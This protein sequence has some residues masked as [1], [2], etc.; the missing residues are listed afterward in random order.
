MEHPNPYDQKHIYTNDSSAPCGTLM[1]F[2][3][4]HLGV[5]SCPTKNKNLFISRSIQS[6]PI[7]IRRCTA[8]SDHSSSTFQRRPP[9]ERPQARKL[10]Q[11][12]WSSGIVHDLGAYAI[13]D[14]YYRGDGLHYISV[15]KKWIH[16]STRVNVRKKKGKKEEV[17]DDG[18][19]G[20]WIT[21]QI[22]FGMRASYLIWRLPGTS[23]LAGDEV[24]GQKWCV[25]ESHPCQRRIAL[26]FICSWLFIFQL[27]IELSI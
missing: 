6:L 11:L 16:S 1:W 15:V 24:P 7:C 18:V 20:G 26:R 13:S 9:I 2:Q 3:K 27:M 12:R 19:C 22:S 21:G 14:P 23:T 8:S 5:K 25:D 17:A 10:R 4:R